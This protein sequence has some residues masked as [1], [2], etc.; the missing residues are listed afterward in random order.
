MWGAPDGKRVEGM[1][2]TNVVR[3][4]LLSLMLA[5]GMAAAGEWELAR[6]RSGIQVWTRDEPGYPIRAFKAVAVVN[7]SLSGLV[8]LI[9]DTDRASQWAY[10]TT[11]IEVLRRDD[12][13]ATF[14]I[15]AETDFPW[16]FSN[17]D[18]VM[19]GQI[20]QDEKT[21]TVT[22]RS[23]STPA[24]QYAPH[25]DFVR[26]PDMTGDWIFR[27]L[28]GGLVEVTMVG[29]AD[30]GGSIPAGLVSLIIHETPYQTL[31]GLRKIIGDERYQRSR[32]QKI[33]EHQD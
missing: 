11:R 16:P 7:S 14:V 17:R 30:P 1:K 18:V 29:R 10:R 3:L 5:C 22:I 9:L 26:M 4:F 25:A 12:E 27:P 8:S 33:R 32:F 19:A 21:R 24:G 15:R 6:D 13:A 28:G 2:V 23:H 31:R 20:I